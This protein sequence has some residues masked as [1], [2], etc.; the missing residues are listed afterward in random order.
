METILSAVQAERH[1]RVHTTLSTVRHEAERQSEGADPH[2]V[3]HVPCVCTRAHNRGVA[4]R[5]SWERFGVVSRRL[6]EGPVG[7]GVESVVP[8]RD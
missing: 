2:T 3:Q 8:V 5:H 1:F 6:R 4:R 7:V